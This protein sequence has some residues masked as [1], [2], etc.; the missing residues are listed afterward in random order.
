MEFELYI[1]A[2]D[3]HELD[4]VDSYSLGDCGEDWDMYM[5]DGS[6]DM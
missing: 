4:I 5:E 6:G 3:S 2:R 1:T